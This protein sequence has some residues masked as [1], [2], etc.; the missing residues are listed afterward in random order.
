MNHKKVAEEVVKAIGGKE[1]VNSLT[2]CVTRLRFKLKDEQIP[3]KEEVEK[4]DGVIQVI[5]KG[6]QYQVVIGNQVEP[7]YN[8][9]IKLIGE[10]TEKSEQKE[11]EKNVKFFDKLTATISG[12]FIPILGLLAATGLLKGILTITMVTGVLN[13]Q[14]DTYKVFNAISDVLFYFFPIFLGGSAA[15]QFKMNQYLGMAIGGAMLYPTLIEIASKGA[16][17]NFL[18]LNINLMN[19]SSSV[20]PVIIAVWVASKLEGGLNK[21]IPQSVKFFIVPLIILVV[22]V[23]ATLA[24]VGPAFTF[25]SQLLAGRIMAIYNFSPILAG[26]LLGGPWI[27]IVMFGL[28]WAFIPIL[29]SNVMLLH[30]DPISGLLGGGQFAMAGASLAVAIKTKD[31]KLKSLSS[32]AGFTCI[33][34]ISEPALYGVLIPLKKPLI[35]SIIGGS[36]G[37]AFSGILGAKL[38]NPGMSGIFSIPAGINPNGVDTGFYGYVGSM[39]VGFIIAFIVTYLW[40]FDNK[41]G[42]V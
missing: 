21:I 30:F 17:I 3:K 42:N 40:K 23:P 13:P 12:I 1:N 18:G 37:G 16:P 24:L 29:I 5:Q 32:S 25:V 15:K 20:F 7:V 11:E 22:M 35:T 10:Q 27:L 39:V 33:L 38:Y 31:L 41:S 4:I 6:G 26:L 19:Y 34:G 9:V 2:H 28:H 36:I 8:E 14:M